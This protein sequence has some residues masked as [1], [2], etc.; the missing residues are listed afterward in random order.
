MN[1]TALLVEQWRQFRVKEVS[2][3]PEGLCNAPG[4]QVNT[5]VQTQL[6]LYL[7]PLVR[8]SHS[9]VLLVIPVRREST[10]P[11]KRISASIASLVTTVPQLRSRCPAPL[12]PPSTSRG[13]LPLRL[14]CPVRRGPT[15]TKGRP[16]VLSARGLS[17]LWQGSAWG[18]TAPSWSP[19]APPPPFRMRLSI[20]QPLSSKNKIQ[21]KAIG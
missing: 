1:G 21:I 10:L 7:A 20:V 16:C 15:P 8:C 18:S 17:V 6:R 5:T 14:V 9:Q 3:H 12:A 13:P 19:R 2:T 11:M 4:V